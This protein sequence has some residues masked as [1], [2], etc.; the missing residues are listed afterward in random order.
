MAQR[1]E[2]V[3][4]RDCG[5]ALRAARKQR[6]LSRDQLAAALLTASGTI[7]RWERNE[8]LPQPRFWARLGELLQVDVMELIGAL[9]HG[10]GD[11]DNVVRMPNSH[12]A[13]GIAS[14]AQ[15]SPWHDRYVEMLFA[16]LEAGFATSA[17]WER[18]ARRA[19]ELVGESWPFDPPTS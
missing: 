4:L 9:P 10:G 3:P 2:A 12:T 1:P 19:G 7:G 13:S 16:G 18:T 11:R 14:N 6:G 17:S 5:G 8:H 15:P